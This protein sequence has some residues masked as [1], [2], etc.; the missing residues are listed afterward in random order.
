MQLFQTL[1]RP[2]Q[3]FAL[4]CRELRSGSFVGPSTRHSLCAITDTDTDTDTSKCRNL[5]FATGVVQS[6]SVDESRF[7][8][9][10]E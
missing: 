2:I 6:V 3:S 10:P 5:V 1:I 9:P 8:H 7:W 4:A